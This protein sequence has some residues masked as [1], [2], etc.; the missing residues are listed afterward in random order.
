MEIPGWNLKVHCGDY[1]DLG[2]DWE[3]SVVDAFALNYL[4]IP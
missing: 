3:N 1:G 2:L 4:L